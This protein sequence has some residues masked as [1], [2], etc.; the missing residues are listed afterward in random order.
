MHLTAKEPNPRLL[1]QPIS[2]HLDKSSLAWF[3]A[4]LRSSSLDAAYGIGT[5]RPLDSGPKLGH[6]VQ[7]GR[8][9]I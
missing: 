5:W 4:S 1:P 2:T 3:P 9:L 8:G 6:D 7:C